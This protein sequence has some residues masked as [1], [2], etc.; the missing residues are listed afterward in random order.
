MEILLDKPTYK[1][2]CVIQEKGAFLGKNEM[3]IK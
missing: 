2:L 1:S 3:I